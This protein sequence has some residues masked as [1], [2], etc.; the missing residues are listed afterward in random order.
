MNIYPLLV[1]NAVLI[2]V[3]FLQKK[4]I[5]LSAI[6]AS[7]PIMVPL[8]IWMLIQQNQSHVEEYVQ[9]LILGIAGTLMFT[10][11]CLLAIRWH[12][13]FYLVFLA[14]WASWGITIFIGKKIL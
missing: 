5:F 1:A 12:L 9:S 11:G 8:T 13:N 6:I 14:G 7:M 3:F 2:L 10:L 4:T